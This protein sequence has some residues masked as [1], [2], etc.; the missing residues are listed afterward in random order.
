MLVLPIPVNRREA[1]AADGAFDAYGR[2][3]FPRPDR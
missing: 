3:V 2:G 1:L